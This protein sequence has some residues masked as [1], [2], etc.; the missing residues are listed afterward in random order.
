MK[1]GKAQSP[2]N[3]MLKDK[4]MKKI[5]YTKESKKIVIKGIN[6]KI[7]IKNKLEGN[8]KFSIKGLN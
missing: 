5:N 4:I 1:N 3:Q 8:H 2:I 7:K 6:V